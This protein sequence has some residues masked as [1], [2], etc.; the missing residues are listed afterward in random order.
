MKLGLVFNTIASMTL[1]IEGRESFKRD[2]N[3][4][5][6]PPYASFRGFVDGLKQGEEDA[7]TGLYNQYSHL[8]HSYAGRV[9]GQYHQ[10]LDDVVNE[11]FLRVYQS[12]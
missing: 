2:H 11:T 7:F 4:P 9:L 6:I 3:R 1:S 12:I 10:D 5:V 8:L